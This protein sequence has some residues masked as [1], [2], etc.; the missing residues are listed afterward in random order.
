ML[1]LK[2]I[3]N[4]YRSWSWWWT[5]I[6]VQELILNSCQSDHE[7]VL[8]L[9]F[10]IVPYRSWSWWWINTGPEIDAVPILFLD[11]TM[12]PYGS[13][14]WYWVH[15][16]PGIDYKPIP[17][18]QM[19]LNSYRSGNTD[20]EPRTDVGTGLESIS[21]QEMILNQWTNGRTN[22]WFWT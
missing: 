11:L 2:L 10:I 18:L 13:R 9:G 17:G 20:T 22:D 7:P 8:V 12:N 4:P 5:H 14:N 21:V 1:V 6:P 16:G 15:I 19:T 3:L